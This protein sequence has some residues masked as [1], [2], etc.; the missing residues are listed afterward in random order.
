MM[1]RMSNS[2]IIISSS[3]EQPVLRV[4]VL[5]MLNQLYI[6]FA[7][8]VVMNLVVV[9]YGRWERSEKKTEGGIET[10]PPP[11]PTP[12]ATPAPTYNDYLHVL[13]A[14]P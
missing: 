13:R 2:I 10:L 14:L 9:P 12:S 1:T 5:M 6:I 4:E 11:L 8:H 3:R 7:M